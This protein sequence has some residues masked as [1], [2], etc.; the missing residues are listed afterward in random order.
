MNKTRKH[1]DLTA[2]DKEGIWNEK[3]ENPAHG[4]KKPRTY[5]KNQGG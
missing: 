5:C 4:S 1:E 3:A 2:Q